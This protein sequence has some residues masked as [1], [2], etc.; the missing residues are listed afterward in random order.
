[1]AKII[2]IE[3]LSIEDKYVTIE[4]TVIQLWTPTSKKIQQTGLIKD[5]TGIIKFTTWASNEL[6]DVE[7]N[8]SY[9]F[10]GFK[11]CE[12]D[13]RLNIQSA[14][15]SKIKLIIEEED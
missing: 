6:P 14:R 8:K 12:W 15:F 7:E 13:G 10:I 1:M 11:V 3:D 4:G 5:E 9:A 2:K